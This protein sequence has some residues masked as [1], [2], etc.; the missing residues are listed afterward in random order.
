MSPAQT[1][2]TAPLSAESLYL[3]ME[4]IHLEWKTSSAIPSPVWKALAAPQG[5]N[6]MPQEAFVPL[7]IGDM[8]LGLCLRL[9]NLHGTLACAPTWMFNTS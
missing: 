8:S 7:G 2:G 4:N 5:T 9:G 6:I 3:G 1:L